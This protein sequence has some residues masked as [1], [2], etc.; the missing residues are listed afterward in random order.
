MEAHG[1]EDPEVEGGAG[2]T[3]EQHLP[4]LIECRR[5]MDR[6]EPDGDLSGDAGEVREDDPTQPC[7]DLD[8][9]GGQRQSYVGK[10][11]HRPTYQR[12]E[13][14][15]GDTE[16]AGQCDREDQVDPDRNELEEEDAF[17]SA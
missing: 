11:D 8:V 7:P 5:P 2:R 4:E 10:P 3:Q 14:D 15:P 16:R 17:C 13:D 12:S 6:E 9:K 1:G